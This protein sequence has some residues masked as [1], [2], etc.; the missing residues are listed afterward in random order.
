VRHDEFIDVSARVVPGGARHNENRHND[1]DQEILLHHMLSTEG[2][3]LVTGDVN[4]DGLDDFVLL[5]ALGDPDKLFIQN[6]NGTFAMRQSAALS[7]DKGFEST[8]GALFDH[9]GDGDLDLMIGSGG[10]QV[11]VD[12]INY[13]VRFYLNDGRG[14]F[15]GD[16]SSI[17]EAIGNFSTL[18]VSDY[19][20]DGDVD[21][22][23]GA[24]LVPGNY[25]LPPQSYLFLNQEGKWMNVA[26]PALGNIGMV[27]DAAWS[28]T[29]GD[30]D[31]DLVVVGDWMSI[32]I[33]KNNNGV[34]E[35]HITV[36]QSS[37]WWNRVVPA[38]LDNDG[39]IDF[40][41]GN[42]GLNT[43]FKASSA[44]PLTMFVNDFDGNG[45]SE[46][47]MNWYAPLDS[48]A[49]PFAT[50]MELVSQLPGLRKSILKY[51]DY[52]PKTYEALFPAQVREGSLAYEANY[53]ASAILWNDGGYFTLASLPSAA[54]VSPVFG[55]L[56]SDFD[57]DGNQDIW[58]GGNFYAMKP[59]VGRHNDSRGVLLRGGAARSFSYEK[60]S[61]LYVEGEVRDVKM[62]KSKGTDK[63]F[64]ARNNAT[65]L[66]F[67]KAK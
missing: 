57:G 47:I 63:V 22:F 65:V 66:V 59:Q 62:I 36:P 4:G 55:I 64:V 44:N 58:L 17:P 32:H 38:D 6:S 25:G 54:Q 18:E 28:D 33:F 60:W 8:C 56:I 48:Q 11:D 12:K 5:G 41:V 13:V 24:R 3:R 26:P 39:D 34:I 50:K 42:W 61:G 46:F 9:D 19:D 30:G 27:T 10:N 37:G 43:K 53:L 21:V 23:L 45:K 15:T 14:N 2:P 40:V 1:F 35:D 16:P 20:Q 49:F 51:E 29:D 31:D 7:R 52:A 67:E